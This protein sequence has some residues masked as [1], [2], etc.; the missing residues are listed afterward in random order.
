MRSAI[1]GAPSFTQNFLQETSVDEISGN[2]LGST[3]MLG[4]NADKRFDTLRYICRKSGIY[5]QV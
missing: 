5:H 4:R 1:Y 3:Y 2:Q